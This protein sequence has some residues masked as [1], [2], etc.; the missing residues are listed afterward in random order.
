MILTKKSFYITSLLIASFDQLTKYLAVSSLATSITVC[1]Y[2]NLILVKNFGISF[3]ILNF[4][5]PIVTTRILIAIFVA[6]IIAFLL[7]IEQKSLPISLVVG[8]ALGNLFDRI[9]L[10]YV[11]DFI[12]IHVMEYHWPA[13]NIADCAVC[14]GVFLYIL[15]TKHNSNGGKNEN[16]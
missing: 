14:I 7:K 2:L 10:G 16:N 5:A 6:S 9:F 11:I 1:D 15:P 4:G 12:D 13:F 3:G 8:G